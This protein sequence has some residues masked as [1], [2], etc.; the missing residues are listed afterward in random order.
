MLR[1]DAEDQL[2]PRVRFQA[3]ADALAWRDGYPAPRQHDVTGL[4]P[5]LDRDEVHRRLADEPCDEKIGGPLVQILG[6]T[7]LLQHAVR[8][9]GNAV[10]HGGGLG[11]VVGDENRGDAAELLQP[12]DLGPQLDLLVG[13]E[14]AQR[15]VEQDHARI[16]HERAAD[17]HPLLRAARQAAHALVGHLGELQ[18]RQDLLDALRRLCARDAAHAQ[19]EKRCSRAPSCCG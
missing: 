18:Q 16:A 17:R 6:R 5:R 14:M 11:L 1:A 12:L 2:G 13:V 4:G 7:D 3:S 10:G 19:A 9:H 15:L 8:H